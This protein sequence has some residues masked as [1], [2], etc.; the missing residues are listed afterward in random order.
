MGNHGSKPQ[1]KWSDNVKAGILRWWMAGMC[2]F[3]VGFGTQ[4]GLF[5][6]PLDLIFFLG[7]GIG[8]VTVCVYNPI[9]YAT[10]DIVKKGKVQNKAYY[11]RKGWENAFIKLQ[12]IFKSLFLVCLVYFTYQNGNLLINRVLDLPA[13]TILIPGEPIG[14]ATLYLLYYQLITGL[15]D[16]IRET[17]KTAE[18]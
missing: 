17:L 10:F 9:A 12:E 13:E 14:F 15:A 4:A 7:V 18:Q 6:E 3:L 11:E 5:A 1:K 2:Y 8:L 16:T